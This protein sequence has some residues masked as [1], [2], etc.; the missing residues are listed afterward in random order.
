MSYNSVKSPIL[1]QYSPFS[2][3]ATK[4]SLR[5]CCDFLD[6]GYKINL[7]IVQRNTSKLNVLKESKIPIEITIH[8]NLE[9]K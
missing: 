7:K 1:V 3:A 8:Q 9:Q 5:M 6:N 2:V 4:N